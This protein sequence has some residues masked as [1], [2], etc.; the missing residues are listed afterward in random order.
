MIREWFNSVQRVVAYYGIADEDIL[1]F[2]EIGFAM[3]LTATAKIITRVEYYDKRS[4][5]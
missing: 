1:N 5:L 3:G 2:N 4:M